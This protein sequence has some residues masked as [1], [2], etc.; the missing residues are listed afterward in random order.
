MLTMF[1]SSLDLWFES[2]WALKNI[3]SDN[4]SDQTNALVSAGAVAGLI[5]LLGSPHLVVAEQAV[6]ALGTLQVTGQSYEV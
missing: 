1:I 4:T 2:V 6:L 5:S 3:T